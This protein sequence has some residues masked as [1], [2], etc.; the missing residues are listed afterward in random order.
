MSGPT[1]GGRADAFQALR[2]SEE[3]HRATLSSISDA[4][5]QTDDDG[6]F[7]YVC[8]NVDVI[9]GYLPDEVHAMG[10]IDR[11]LGENLFDP[12]ELASRGE[13]R[14]L[15]RDVVTKSGEQRT[16]LVLLR[17][18]AIQR[19][20]LLYTC[21][22]VT[23]LKRA[24][25]E[26]AAMRIELAH[27]ARLALVGELTASIVHDIRQPLTALLTNADSGSYLAASDEG[28]RRTPDLREIFDDIRNE[29]RTVV[30]IVDRL[31]NLVRKRPLELRACQVNEVVRD[32]LALVAAD[33]GRRRV[34]LEADLATPLPPVE[35]D[36]I[37][38]QQLLLNLVV[39]AMDSIDSGGNGQRRVVVRTRR[40]PEEIELSV[41]DD[42]HG[43][44]TANLPKIFDAFY[45]TK[46]DGIGLGLA[47]ARTIVDAHAGRIWVDGSAGHGATFHVALPLRVRTVS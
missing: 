21:R 19:G 37:S 25:R 40:S 4:V 41:S 1:N 20:T 30:E 18:V 28:A 33:A 22:D 15:E 29:C 12:A 8:P 16:V 38:L 23:E 36:R 42:G 24:E 13:I 17:R 47:I 11:L 45:S 2:D 27:A 14:N 31:R 34:R 26:L 7:T 43:I 35:A 9:F 5:F 39:N 32:V 46:P 6:V 44:D 10:R 3:L